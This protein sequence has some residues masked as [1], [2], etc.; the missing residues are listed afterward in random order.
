MPPDVAVLIPCHNEELTIADVVADFRTA[1]PTCLIYGYDN[2]S[3]DN[4]VVRACKAGDN[5]RA[6]V[7]KRVPV[8]FLRPIQSRRRERRG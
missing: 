1:L 4:T 6:D 3:T 7:V 8:N 2:N 5:I